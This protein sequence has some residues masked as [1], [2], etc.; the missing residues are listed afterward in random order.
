MIYISTYGYLD[1]E[2]V[3]T[4]FFVTNEKNLFGIQNMYFNLSRKQKFIILNIYVIYLDFFY[5]RIQRFGIYE[6]V[7]REYVT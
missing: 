5:R 2:G 1:S 7:Y 4:I 3:R 6:P